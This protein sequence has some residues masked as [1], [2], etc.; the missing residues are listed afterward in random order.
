VK[1]EF[2]L[3]HQEAADTT[4]NLEMMKRLVT[5][6]W[7]AFDKRDFDSAQALLHQSFEA[8]WPNT[9]ERFPTAKHFIDANRNYPGR[10][11]IAIV[12]NEAHG[13]GVLTVVEVASPDFPS[14]MFS[15]VSFFDFA[16]G[17]ISRLTEYWGDCAE[18]PEW[19][20]PYAERYGT[21]A[22][23]IG[24]KTIAVK[25]NSAMNIAA[26]ENSQMR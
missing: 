16:D 25:T 21:K 4:A 23:F 19:H 1:F 14:Q 2:V 6:F 17:R 9:R 24:Q 5:S 22:P 7:D 13:N 10:W 3:N 11:R 12:R 26:E 20:K 15:A 18:P 8:L